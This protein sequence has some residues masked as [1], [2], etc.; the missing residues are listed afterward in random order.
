MTYRAIALDLDGTLLDQQK[1]ILPQSLEALALARQQGV[2]VLI[3]T[4]RHHSAIHPFYQALELDT[5]ALCCNGTYIYNY[6]IKKIEAANPLRK[7]QA[8]KVL[9]LLDEFHINGL[10]YVDDAMLY[11]RSNDHVVRL[12]KW[13]HSLPEAQRPTMLHVDSLA[14]SAESA[15]AIWKVAISHHNLKELRSFSHIVEQEMGLACEWSWKDQVDIAQGGNNKG[16]LLS[17]WAT[18]QGLDMSQVIAF[19][20][21]FNDV[22]ML[23][24]SGLGVAM[25]NSDPEV[26]AKADIVIADNEQPGIAD[27]IRSRVLS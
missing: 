16:K 19:G 5:P 21:N 26:K 24:M 25:G 11:Q 20:D 13:S 4:G 10:L 6:P 9:E 18:S 27:I 22:S 3:V 15:E 23:E 8:V 1:K 7:E 12:T 2:K 14:Q 17:E